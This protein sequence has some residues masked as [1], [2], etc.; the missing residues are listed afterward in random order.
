MSFEEL[1]KQFEDKG[2]KIDGDTFSLER[3]NGY[4]TVVNNGQ[5]RKIP[6]VSKF[7]MKYIGDGYIVNDDGDSDEESEQLY[8]FDIYGNNGELSATICIR[9]YDDFTVFVG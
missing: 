1:K 9:D 6:N 8:S 5:V 3:V 4:S 7:E 2:F